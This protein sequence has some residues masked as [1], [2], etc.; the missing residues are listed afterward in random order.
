MNHDYVLITILVPY[1]CT[2]FKLLKVMFVNRTWFKVVRNYM[3]MQ[4]KLV[5]DSIFQRYYKNN[6]IG[7]IAEFLLKFTNQVAICG[8][9]IAHFLP[10]NIAHGYCVGKYYSFDKV[11]K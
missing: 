8:Y 5:P 6:E 7:N 3:I 1:I 9:Q 10:N 2:D 4:G 11:I